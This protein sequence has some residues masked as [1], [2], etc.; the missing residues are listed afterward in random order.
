MQDMSDDVITIDVDDRIA[1]ITLNRPEKRNAIND[2]TMEALDS[3][4]SRVPDGVKVVVLQGA[5]GH[6]SSGL[7]LSEMVRRTPGEVVRHS[8]WWH[9]VMDRIQL[10]GVPVVAILSGAVMGGGLE[11][12]AACHVRIAEPTARFQLP[13]GR[14]GIFVGGG[15]TVR[16]SRI[17]GAD[18][19]VEMMLTGRLYDAE[20]G[21]RLG[22]AHYLVG[23]G[24]GTAK[25]AALASSI[26]DNSSMVNYLITQA[27]PHI[28]DMASGDGL[29][30]ESLAAALSQTGPDA[31]EGLRAFLE[32]RP[33]KFS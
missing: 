10:G 22:L 14:R 26:A 25:A 8:R 28:Q 33:P 9:S 29:L 21:T 2:A 4:F 24:E 20:E 27:I 7:D 17:L 18:R 32:K 6:F 15:A 16:I 19:L 30:T 1:R 11:I 12:A 5:G 3:F 13:E 31:E 23:D